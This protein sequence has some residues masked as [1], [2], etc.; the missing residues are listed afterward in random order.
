MTVKRVTKVSSLPIMSYKDEDGVRCWS[1]DMVNRTVILSMRDVELWESYCEFDEGVR[2]ALAWDAE[3]NTCDSASLVEELYKTRKEAKR[4][5][6]KSKAQALKLLLNSIY[7]RTIMKA[8]RHT[9]ELLKLTETE[10]LDR[11]SICYNRLVMSLKLSG[12]DADGR[13][14]YLL[15]Q[16]KPEHDYQN[17]AHWGA[18]ILSWSKVM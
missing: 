11:L 3:P 10:H 7:G 15:K 1:N 17:T 6:Q 12:A 16:T 13:S 4:N 14:T 2:Y 5:K 8:P 9:T 18:L